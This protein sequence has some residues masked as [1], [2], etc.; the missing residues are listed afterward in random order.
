MTE[1]EIMRI[2]NL[3]ICEQ[4]TPENQPKYYHPYFTKDVLVVFGKSGGIVV[5]PYYSDLLCFRRI[6]EY[7]GNY[8]LECD[9]PKEKPAMD[10]W[11]EYKVLEVTMGWVKKYSTHLFSESTDEILGFS[12]PW[13]INPEEEND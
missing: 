5:W 8:W 11:D 13:Q 6:E 10:L 1:N 7:E 9:G 12:L 2:V 4:F 3:E